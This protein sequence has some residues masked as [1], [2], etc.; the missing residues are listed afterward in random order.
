MGSGAHRRTVRRAMPS[1]LH[2]I[3]QWCTWRRLAAG[4]AQARQH[5][6]ELLLYRRASPMLSAAFR[7][8]HHGDDLVMTALV[9]VAAGRRC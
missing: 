2:R 7:V 4:L 1:G 8:A 6:S 9:N 5:V 3:S